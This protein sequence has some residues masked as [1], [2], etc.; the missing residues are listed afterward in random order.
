MARLKRGW[1]PDAQHESKVDGQHQLGAN[2]MSSDV[3]VWLRNQFYNR[4]VG[5]VLPVRWFAPTP[6]AA[7]ELSIPAGRLKL[8]IVSHSWQYAHLSQ[9]QLSSIVNYP[10]TDCELIYTL[11]HAEEDAGMGALVKRFDSIEVPNV[12]WDWQVLP[13]EALFRRAIGR[14]KASLASEA[15]WLW[16][17]DCDLI[18][19]KGCLDS[20]AA[21]LYR[22]QALLVFPDHEGITE[23]LPAEHPMLN[24]SLDEQQNID[25]DP[26]LFYRNEITKAKGA[27]QIVHGDVA[28]AVGYCGSLSLY[29]E[30]S[31]VWRKTYED[32]VFRRLL[33]TEGEPVP[34]KSLYRIRHAEKGRYAKGSAL[35]SVRGRLRRLFD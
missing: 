11:F 18:F 20:L 26:A 17:A 14:H 33:G 25:I 35:S 12:T 10:P 21:A 27:F 24:Q 32:T 16:F 23:L 34:V 22:K 31:G 19:H 4:I 5:S 6:P 8:Q 1:W 30:P 29:Q 7:N 15:D 2:F 9:F 13:R 28:R 3:S